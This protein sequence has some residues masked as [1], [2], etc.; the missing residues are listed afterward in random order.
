MNRALAHLRLRL[1]PIHRALA[2]AVERQK[3]AAA[4][5]TQSDLS[6]F[7]VTDDQVWTLLSQ[8]SEPRDF[9]VVSASLSPD[10]QLLEDELRVD[11][12]LPLDRL[13]LTPF[14]E[15]ALLLCAAPELD[16]SY[17]RIY[18]FI[19]DDLNRRFPCVELITSLTAT[20]ME[21]RI[22]QRHALAPHGRL[23]R[24]EF[25]LPFG[26][27]PA[28]YRQEL[29][30]APG[31]FDYLTG[32]GA[33][34]SKLC[35]DRAEIAIPP[36]TV[37]LQTDQFVHLCDALRDGGL[38]TLGIWGPRRNGAEDLIFGLSKALDRPL[39][40]LIPEADSLNQQWTI[41]SSLNALLWFDADSL[42]DPPRDRALAEMLSGCSVPV[43]ITSEFPWRGASALLSE[44][45][46]EIELPPPATPA[47]EELWSRNLPEL[48]REE[49]HSLAS[50]YCLAAADVRSAS[51]LARTR[52]RLAGNGVPD[53]VNLHIAA[54][55]SVVT[56]R[57]SN[58]FAA[59]AVPRR[60]PGDLI[61]PDPLYRQIIEVAN[62]FELQSRVDHDWGFGR[63]A[64]GTG[65]KVLF[66]GDP[67]TGKTLSAE[68][69]AA[70]LSLTLY[71]V[72]LARIVSK[73]VGET[74]KNL[75]ATFQEAEESHSVLFFDEAEALFGKRGEVQSGTDRYAN[76][77][78]SYLLQRLEASRGL[79][80]LA[81]NVKD[82]IDAAFLRRFHVV[83]N[84]PRPGVPE[85]LRL[86]RLAFPDSAPVADLDFNALAR[87]DLTG[88]A[89]MG[90]AR[91]AALLAADSDA[92]A[93][94]MAHVIQA[95]ARQFR[96]EARVLT[97][98]DLGSYGVLLQGA[99]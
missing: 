90:A 78:V 12:D 29:R 86:W 67:G 31:L 53:P 18:A 89:I 82:Q 49:V 73:W 40:R 24:C 88:A 13:R 80:I 79:V 14:E 17:E 36:E 34:M 22:L 3:E 30:L 9:P 95:T 91:T 42:A 68:V 76:L 4:R 83:V 85:R 16:R 23:R 64:T 41:A 38:T 62:F 27:P 44:S 26:D 52:A 6:A 98:G 94:T 56:R 7:C 69:I 47:R 75:D 96:R 65:T 99:S 58:R 55:C 33:D 20:S 66:T 63:L 2:A 37:A 61:L 74:E 87:L 70:M 5:L 93:I 11:G 46:A 28:G 15:Q 77:E 19:L 8:L 10:E 59:P 97:P 25:L 45:Y 1:R 50:R 72:D 57:S 48:D 21:E 60:G 51:Q 54:A 39:R 81:S 92:P 84:F 35:R 32:G 71:K 43:F